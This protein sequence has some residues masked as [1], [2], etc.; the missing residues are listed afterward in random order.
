MYTYICTYS[1]SAFSIICYYRVLNADD[2]FLLKNNIYL[3]LHW[4]FLASDGL[5]LVMANGGYS[6]FIV[7]CMAVASLVAEYRL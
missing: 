1:F 4:I 2:L 7:V 6:F 3:W 5:S